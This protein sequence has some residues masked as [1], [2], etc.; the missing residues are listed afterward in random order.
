MTCPSSL[1]NITL[2]RNN[3]EE[4]KTAVFMPIMEQRVIVHVR[5][6]EIIDEGDDVH[7]ILTPE[8]NA[9]NVSTRYILSKQLIKA[10][11]EVMAV[12]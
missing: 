5:K 10:L 8:E 4:Y 6:Y 9:G 1:D 11:K 3:P 2:Q 7:L 12:V